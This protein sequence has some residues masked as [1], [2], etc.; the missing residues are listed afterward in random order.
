MVKGIDI[1]L[2]FTFG[3]QGEPQ[4]RNCFWCMNPVTIEMDNLHLLTSIGVSFFLIYLSKIKLINERCTGECYK[5]G[6]VKLT[7]LGA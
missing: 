4:S 2:I 3:R 5:C 6:S 1:A 7:E